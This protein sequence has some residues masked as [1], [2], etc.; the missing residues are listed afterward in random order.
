MSPTAKA[1][2]LDVWERHNGRNNGEISY[3][4]REAEAIGVSR[5]AA[6]RAFNELLQRGFLK[7]GRNSSFT[8]K[9][10]EARTW[11]LTAEPTGQEAGVKASRDYMTWSPQN[12]NTVPERASNGP[13]GGTQRGIAKQNVPLESLARD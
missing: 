2:L 9:T 1:V 7:V 12:Q 8:L 5:S 11:E 3:S 10:K 4:V 13:A 6:A